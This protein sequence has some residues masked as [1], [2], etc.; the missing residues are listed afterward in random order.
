MLRCCEC[1]RL[2]DEPIKEEEYS[3]Y[4][5]A[6]GW[7]G[8]YVSPCCREAFEEYEEDEENDDNV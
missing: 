6:P 3:E 5:G 1:G 2:F 8:Y 7:T 4:W